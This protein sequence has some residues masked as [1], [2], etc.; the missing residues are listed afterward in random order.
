MKSERWA[1]IN[2]IKKVLT[3]KSGIGGPMFL[4]KD[5]QKYI[6]GKE[7]HTIA[8]GVSGS[9]KTRRF[10]LPMLRSFIEAKESFIV[11]DPKGDL[12]EN[13]AVYAEKSHKVYKIDFRHIFESMCWNPL[14]APYELYASGDPVKK[15]VAIEMLDQLAHML[16]STD[17]KDPFWPEQA[18]DLFLGVCYALFEN[19]EKEQVSMAG[20]HQFITKGDERFGGGTY[21]KEF[22]NHL[23]P[24]SNAAL[25]LRSYATTASETAGGIRSSCL[26]PLNMFARSEGLVEMLGHDDLQ[27][28]SLDG[29]TPTAIYIIIP[30]ETPIYD[31]LAGVLISQLMGHYVRI[32]HDKYF[33]K[34]PCRM[35]VC[36][37]ELGNIGSAIVNLDHLM[38]A[39]RSRNLRI[40]MILQSLSQLDDIYGESKA[41]T[42]TSNADVM[43]AFRVNH[44]QTLQE[45]SKKCGEREIDYG[46]RISQ[47]P[48]ISEISLGAMQTGQALVNISGATKFITWLP[49]YSEVYDTS[50]WKAPEHKVRDPKEKVKAFD[51]AEYVKAVKKKKLQELMK[52]EEDDLPFGRPMFNPFHDTVQFP[53]IDIDSMIA[54]ID[55]QIAKLDE[56]EAEN[57]DEQD[58]MPYRVLLHSTNGNKVPVIKFIRN[59]RKMSLRDA[60]ELVDR[61]PTEVFR[62]SEQN[63]AED[64][65][66]ELRKLGASVEIEKYED[67]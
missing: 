27:I 13:T 1:R 8:L 42:I 58:K 60:K 45:L 19:A 12:Y 48:L 66:K 50:D 64:F 49:D 40:Q 59:F 46:N 23:P 39:G 34:L 10:M 53:S 43:I 33:G 16:Y 57:E 62:T 26:G 17:V 21:L 32:A 5:G 15:Q 36:L 14:C 52:Q 28:N 56:L 41:S 2:E 30:D 24:E 22:I 29:E 63:V 54:D 20:I 18:R 11:P 31:R 51:I 67:D 6:Y 44:W 37:E 9:G 35:N 25:L 4:Y 38:S 7:G 55:R 61:A 47:E 3:N 65:C